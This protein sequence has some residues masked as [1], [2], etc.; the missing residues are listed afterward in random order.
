MSFACDHDVTLR[1]LFDGEAVIQYKEDNMSKDLVKLSQMNA[2]MLEALRQRGFSDEQIINDALARNLPLDDSEFEFDF[3]EL[4]EYVTQE[5]STV[6]S[7]LHQGYQM[8]YN[9][10]RGIRCWI[11]IVF[12]QEPKLVFDPGQEA[13]YATL[14]KQQQQQLQKAISHGWQLSILNENTNEIVIKPTVV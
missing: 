7:A 9:T 14:N 11:V 5:L 6:Q 3:N 13:V 4:S 10:I 1:R 8:K 12:G 2:L